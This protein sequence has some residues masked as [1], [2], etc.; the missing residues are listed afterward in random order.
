[1]TRTPHVTPA[2]QRR[3]AAHAMT[4]VTCAAT[5]PLCRRTIQI[6]S[7][8][9][10]DYEETDESFHSTKPFMRILA[11]SIGGPGGCLVF[12]LVSLLTAAS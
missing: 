1:M 12:M 11:R 2:L 6:Q 9:Q 4:E 8:H 3:A 7:Q 10:H 5:S